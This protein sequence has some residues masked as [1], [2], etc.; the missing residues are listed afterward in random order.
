M[1]SRDINSGPFQRLREHSEGSYPSP[2]ESSTESPTAMQIPSVRHL[3][4][5]NPDMRPPHSNFSSPPHIFG[6]IIEPPRDPLYLDEQRP[7]KVKHH[8]SGDVSD[9]LSSHSGFHS[10]SH[11]PTPAL[12]SPY[13][14]SIPQGSRSSYASPPRMAPAAAYMGL[15]DELQRPYGRVSSQSSIEARDDR[16]VS[17]ASLLSNPAA[18]ERPFPGKLSV[19]STASSDKSFYGV[20][21]GLPDLDIPKNDDQNALSDTTPKLSTV[22]PVDPA[23]SDAGIDDSV[24]V[25]GFALDANNNEEYEAYYSRPVPVRISCALEPLPQE[26]SQNPMN[27]LYFHHFLD[28]TA[29]ILV[30]HDCSENPFKNILPKS[31]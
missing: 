25:F 27:L 8:S 13:R 9:L 30:P 7:K 4:T 21:R 15:G 28:H 10:H 14:S 17:V 18:D 6:N 3:P 23:D 24:S 20:D 26:L 12:P 11:S 29:R 5:S 31:T 19:A 1:N 22:G 16:R 2:A